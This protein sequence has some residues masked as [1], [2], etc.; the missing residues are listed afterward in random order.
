MHFRGFAPAAL[1]VFD[2]L[3]A[4][5]TRETFHALKPEYERELRAPAMDLVADLNSAFAARDVPLQGDPKRALFRP[6]RDVRFARDK[7]PYKTNVGFVMTRSGDKRDAG[8]FY[9][10]LGLDGVFAALGFYVMEPPDLAAVREEILEHPGRWRDV[11]RQ[12]AAAGLSLSRDSL[13]KR[14]PRG[15]PPDSP[16]DLHEALRLKSLTVS[17]PLS[18]AQV[19]APALV[20]NLARL[21]ADALPLLQF[22]WRALGG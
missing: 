17:L 14:L 8:L 15:V 22:G 1:R 5:N 7:S 19:A 6:N 16:A 20:D 2:A 18:P 3:A 12:L 9:F 21:A 10:Q 11:E 4:D 13:A